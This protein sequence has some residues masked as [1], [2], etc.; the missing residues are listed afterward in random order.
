MYKDV[1]RDIRVM[2]D[3]LC[4]GEHNFASSYLSAQNKALPEYRLPYR[5]LV[6][7]Y[8]VTLRH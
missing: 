1:M 7:G 6:S 3:R 5:V 2:L 8:S 4:I